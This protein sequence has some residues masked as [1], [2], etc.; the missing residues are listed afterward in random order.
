MLPRNRK[1]WELLQSSIGNEYARKSIP[2]VSSSRY[3]LYSYRMA[4]NDSVIEV[5][6]PGP[7]VPGPSSGRA[8]DVRTAVEGS[9]T[10]G[11]GVWVP[12]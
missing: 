6:R 11:H 3:K 5:C 12:Q 8:G 9:S 2:A 10:R 7:W 4:E 1:Y